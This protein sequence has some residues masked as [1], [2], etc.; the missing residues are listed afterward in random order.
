ML[1]QHAKTCYN[2]LKLVSLRCTGACC[3]NNVSRCERN[4]D[5]SWMTEPMH[6][7]LAITSITL[8]E[9]ERLLTCTQWGFWWL[10]SFCEVALCSWKMIRC[11]L[12]LCAGHTLSHHLYNSALKISQV[13]KA[14]FYIKTSQHDRHLRIDCWEKRMC[15]D[16]VHHSLIPPSKLAASG[17]DVMNHHVQCDAQGDAQRACQSNNLTLRRTKLDKDWSC[18]RQ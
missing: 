11:I 13:L 8:W 4:L 1:L 10:Q 6:E 2:V 16:P 18:G 17:F 12:R 14:F 15:C 3:E 7:H 5:Q 9:N